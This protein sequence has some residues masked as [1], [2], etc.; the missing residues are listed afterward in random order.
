MSRFVP[1]GFPRLPAFVTPIRSTEDPRQ[2]RVF[3]LLN[4]LR[5][6]VVSDPATD[7]AAAAMDVSVGHGS[8]PE[9]APG[10]AHFVEH[11]LFLGSA[12]YPNESEYRD[13]LSQNG[14]RSN[15]GTSYSS[16]SF[17]FDVNADH[18][19]GALDRFAQF[20]IAP[21]FTETATE[22]E[23]Q[24]VDSEHQRNLQQDSNRLYQLSK[25]LANPACTFSKF[26]TGSAATLQGAARI[27]EIML[28]FHEKHYSANTMA[29]CVV[30]KESVE[31]LTELVQQTF[32]ACKNK[33]RVVVVDPAPVYLPNQLQKRISVLAVKD[34]HEMKITWVLPAV[35]EYWKSSPLD[36]IAH[37]LGHEGEKSIFA[38]IKEK[39]WATALSAGPDTSSK[40][41]SLFSVNVELTEEGLSH[42]DDIF[43]VVESYLEM[44]RNMPVQEWQRHT[45]EAADIS[46]IKFRFKEK[47]SPIN[48]ASF[49]A[50]GLSKYSPEFLLSAPATI[51][52][53]D[54]EL[55]K[56]LCTKYLL[57]Q[58]SRL[59]VL[60]KTNSPK[61]TLAE[62]W[63]GT[64]YCVED[65][66]I[67]PSSEVSDVSK[68]LASP[69][70]NPFIP[71]DFS[72]RSPSLSP[73]PDPTLLPGESQFS[74]ILRIHPQAQPDYS[75][76]LIENTDSLELWHKIGS[77]AKPR[78]FFRVQLYSAI[79]KLSIVHDC[80]AGLFC[81]LIQDELNEYAYDAQLAGLS[82]QVAKFIGFQITVRGYS[83]K[84][85]IL[86]EKIVKKIESFEL[87]DQRRFDIL[88][89]KSLRSLRN[90]WLG[91]PAQHSGFWTN[92]ALLSS[93]WHHTD[94][95][96]ALLAM[97]PQRL[98][99]CVSEIL[100]Q[101]RAQMVVF[102]NANEAEAR[103]VAGMVTSSLVKQ[104]LPLRLHPALRTTKLPNGK[105]YLLSQPVENEK[106][107]NAACSLYFQVGIR[108]PSFKR[109]ALLSIFG[110]IV[111]DQAF[112]ELRTKQQLG[113]VVASTVT[114]H[115]GVYGWRV[116]VQS[117]AYP[118]RELHTR[119]DEFLSKFV[120]SF[121]PG[122]SDS[123]FQKY[124][125][126]A[127]SLILEKDKSLNQE[128]ERLWG[129]IET[130]NFD[131]H[132]SIGLARKL[133][134]IT[135]PELREF[136]DETI[137]NRT[138]RRKFAVEMHG[139]GDATAS[140]E[141]FGELIAPEDLDFWRNS[142]ETY[143]ALL[144]A[145]RVKL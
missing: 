36:V 14:G 43:H 23:M 12:K 15:A 103:A 4:G 91:Q 63:Y 140:S 27:R 126:A 24:A 73:R 32:S 125:D 16:T 7:K 48:Y 72:L 135:L 83:E 131:F 129:S 20:F 81:S 132:Q 56:S 89:E 95:H 134:E 113:Y 69:K 59:V 31:E 88:K 49:V 50:R 111:N 39:G 26:G 75:P 62:K 120:S 87:K 33:N 51:I 101:T 84:A 3:E 97:T 127:C 65:L 37:L 116:Y 108:D 77:F 35:E 96:A 117:A 99:Q 53:P 74:R 110:Q 93:A 29:L 86:L 90:F 100:A 2:Y 80:A 46:A 45:K 121:L 79:C 106:D 57:T 58:N 44:L 105:D 143:P 98:M 133:Q 41:F 115:E 118:A 70:P 11:M 34:I 8:D 71:N 25:S 17:F 21:L 137:V 18:L 22:R 42:V 109:T 144:C 9:N 139:K 138:T 136:V 10:C 67:S 119:I 123:D 55:S 30:G 5:V 68:H 13:F 85:P 60:S 38:F 92:Y 64:M 128:A 102:G 112:T 61:T 76:K 122:I 52:E 114:A 142:M 28:D 40:G 82:Y 19:R 54:A 94:Q 107:K 78:V 141:N 130:Y 6:A 124:K 66:K 145:C 104:P 47:E 1:P